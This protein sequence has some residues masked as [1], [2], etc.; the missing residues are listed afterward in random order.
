M[1][2]CLL[3]LSITDRGGLKSTAMTVDL[4]VSSFSSDNFC[5]LYFEALLLDEHIY[6]I[7]ISY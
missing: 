7:V 3:A 4:S 6:N 1:Y 2:F 5:L